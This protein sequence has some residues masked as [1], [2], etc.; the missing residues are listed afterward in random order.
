MSQLSPKSF[1]KLFATVLTIMLMSTGIASAATPTPG[2]GADIFGTIAAPEGVAAYNTQ[3]GTGGLGLMIF[4]SN[5]IKLLTI[6]AGLWV[7]VNFLMAGWSIITSAGDSGATKKAYDKILM[8]VI[9]L[10]IIIGSYTL[11]ALISLLLFGR[12]DF[13]LN[14]TITGAK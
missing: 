1:I 14:P 12:A 11:V 13:I 9:G 5:I 7:F 4:F 2:T 3:A 8:S 6:V 10:V